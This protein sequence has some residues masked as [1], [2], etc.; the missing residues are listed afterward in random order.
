MMEKNNYDKG[1][2]I[3]GTA[4]IGL[5]GYYGRC[6]GYETKSTFSQLG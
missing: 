4:C 2:L 6:V 1:E 5:P 3:D